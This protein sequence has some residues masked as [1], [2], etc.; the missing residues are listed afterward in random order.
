MESMEDTNLKIIYEK[1]R[2]KKEEELH[3]KNIKLK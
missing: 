2:E 1:E 3:K